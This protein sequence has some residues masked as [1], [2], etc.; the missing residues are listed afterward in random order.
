MFS[1]S[2]LRLESLGGKLT[3]SFLS[4]LQMVMNPGNSSSFIIKVSAHICTN[5]KSYIS[6]CSRLIRI[7]YFKNFSLTLLIFPREIFNMFKKGFTNGFVLSAFKKSMLPFL[8]QK[9]IT[10]TS[11]WIVILLS[12]LQS[13]KTSLASSEQ[14]RGDSLILSLSSRCST[15]QQ[16]S[17]SGGVFQS[18]HLS[19]I[20]LTLA[21]AIH[22]TLTLHEESDR[23]KSS[24]IFI[25]Y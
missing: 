15:W 11:C 14:D 2:I 9:S 20:C 13:L 8:L 17:L 4:Y 22:S 6:V 10:W 16:S 25:M 1:I 23:R 7:G 12:L 19:T 3:P 21:V 5:A 18:V 24:T